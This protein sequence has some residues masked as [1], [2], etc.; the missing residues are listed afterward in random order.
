L[1]GLA[2]SKF[3]SYGSSSL[4]N[5]FP[6][7]APRMPGSLNLGDAWPGGAPTPG[8]A[9]IVAPS[10]ARVAY[11]PWLRLVRPLRVAMSQSLP[12]AGAWAAERPA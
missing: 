3:F 9:S 6:L 4:S 5:T 8:A 2:E 11:P 7:P 1:L 10:L 12:L